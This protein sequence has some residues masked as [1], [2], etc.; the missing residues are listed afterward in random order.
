MSVTS[1]DIG[2]LRVHAL[3]DGDR[4]IDAMTECFPAIPADVLE[5][6]NRREPS[7]YGPD[8][9]WRLRT[10]GFLI[11]HPSGLIAVDTGIGPATSPAVDWFG[12]TGELMD[13]FAELEV[14]PASVAVMIV[15]HVHDDHIGG[16]TTT[17]GAPAFPNARY[18]I[19]HSDWNWVM[20]FVAEDP[21]MEAIARLLLEPLEDAGI[22]DLAEG[23]I[24]IADGIE[25]VHLPGHT[26]GH[27]VVRIS[28]GG[29]H[30]TLSGDTFN[31]P[32]Q[33]ANPVWPAGSDDDPEQAERSRR[34][35]LDRLAEDGDTVATGHFADAF[36]RI[37]REGDAFAW[38]P[39]DV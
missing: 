36:G 39:L 38:N 33:L 34:A 31:H 12:T 20:G 29:A 13:R 30:L 1:I 14:D 9:E 7:I 23:D 17:Q 35:L 21:E 10:R 26:P 11:E 6:W 8:G 4:T 5:D 2:S 15:T 28:S 24:R 18:V 3:L 32:A 37:S 22:V 27:Q 19:Q 16:T 25:A